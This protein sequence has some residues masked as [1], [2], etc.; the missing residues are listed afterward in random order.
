MSRGCVLGVRAGRDRLWE[1]EELARV[2][3]GL[4]PGQVL[5]VEAVVVASRL[6]E[7][8][9]GE[10]RVNAS[11]APWSYR[12]PGLAKPVAGLLPPARRSVCG[13]DHCMFEQEP[14]LSMRERGGIGAHPVVGPAPRREIEFAR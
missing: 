10:V 9:V 7:V 11:V 2:V 12:S 4:D 3:A 8:V 5:V 1:V 13:N 6:V 14:G